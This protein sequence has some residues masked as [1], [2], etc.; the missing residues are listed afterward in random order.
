MVPG[1]EGSSKG[2]PNNMYQR[3]GATNTGNSN[4]TVVPGMS[5]GVNP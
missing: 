2:F 5:S 4:G 3:G 1:M